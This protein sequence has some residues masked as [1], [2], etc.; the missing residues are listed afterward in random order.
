MS[1]IMIVGE[2]SEVLRAQGNPVATGITIN[3][4]GDSP[5]VSGQYS[6]IPQINIGIMTFEEFN[7]SASSYTQPTGHQAQSPWNTVGAVGLDAIFSPYSTHTDSGRSPYL[8]Y[9]TEPSE[10]TDEPTSKTLNPFN[11][12]NMLSGMKSSGNSL[13]SDV[14]MSSGHNISFALSYDPYDSGVSGAS[15]YVGSE[16]T[17]PDGS[18]SPTDH[19]F[20]KD[21]FVRHT[22]ETQ[23]IRGVGLRSPII[24]TGWGFDIGGNPVPALS[25]NPHPEAAWNPSLWKSGPVDLR[26]DDDRG[27]WTAVGGSTDSVWFTID[28][29]ICADSYDERRLLATPDWSTGGCNTAIPGIDSYTGQITIYDICNVLS[30]YTDDGLPGLVG[31]ATYMYP[32]TGGCTP[33]WIVDT[34]CGETEC[35]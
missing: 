30:Y 17:Y 3:S 34:I 27:V 22:V 10:E 21:H 15:G 12:F 33:K 8:P 1:N 11:P 20:E 26:W 5:I 2:I 31:R 19:F 24:L 35:G 6:I 14:W 23:G 32:R 7:E 29:S 18:G 9:F 4:F 13:E 16:G 25:G 28:E